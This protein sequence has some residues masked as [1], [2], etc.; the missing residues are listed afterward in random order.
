M[1]RVDVAFNCS[2][3]SLWTGSLFGGKNSKERS[4]PLDQRPVHRLQ[5]EFQHHHNKYIPRSSTHLPF[6]A[7]TNKM[8][9]VL[10]VVFS[11]NVNTV[12]C[13]EHNLTFIWKY[14]FFPVVIYCPTSSLLHLSTS[15]FRFSSRTTIFFFAN[16]LLYP[17]ECNTLCTV[18]WLKVFVLHLFS[19]AVM[20]CKVSRLLLLT[21]RFRAFL[22]LFVKL[23]FLSL[24]VKVST[25]P[26]LRYL[27]RTLVIVV[28]GMFNFLD[29]SALFCTDSDGVIINS[30]VWTVQHLFDSWELKIN[31]HKRNKKKKYMSLF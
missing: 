2:R 5:S 29:S 15:F 9:I 31:S 16:L 10:F 24:R 26:V 23:L 28:F 30:F 19:F 17:S 22:S 14:S 6:R 13:T 20:S 11:P 7:R 4:S 18:F 27:L 3:S 25:V 8:W 12:V 1:Y 21:K